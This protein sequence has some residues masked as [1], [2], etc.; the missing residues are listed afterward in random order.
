MKKTQ[1]EQL[2]IHDFEEQHFHLPN[3]SH[4]YYELV[5]IWHGSGQHVLNQQRMPYQ[6]GDLFVIS[7]KDEHYFEI[8]ESTR[9]TFIKFTDGYF[10]GHTFYRPEAR[11]SGSPEAVM[12]LP[13]LKQMKLQIDE[14]CITILRQT[15]DNIVAYNCRKNVAASPLV[16]YQVLS[17]LGLIREAAAKLN[18]QISYHEPDKEDLISYI[19]GHIHLPEL[20]QVK[21]I[22]SHFA[23]SATYFGDYFKRNFEV[24]YRK[25]IDAYR[26]QLIEQRLLTA[27]TPLKNIAAEFGFQDASHLSKYFR[28][29]KG[30]GTR[31]FRLIQTI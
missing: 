11:A 18:L 13:V 15:I 12:R 3:H 30:I 20:L 4:T 2:V 29:Q 17:V 31:E 25:Y 6:Q 22:A 10:A 8:A 21:H 14:P 28:S 7:P 19:H 23:I 16:F 26:L 24:S 1:F 5:Y 27:K 9:F